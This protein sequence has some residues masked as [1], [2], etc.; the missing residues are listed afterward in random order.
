MTISLRIAAALPLVPDPDE[1]RRRAAEELAKPEYEAAQPTPLD[2]VAQAVGDF[3][4]GILSGEAPPGWDGLLGI[5]VV[6][7]A[8]LL[9]V[10]AVL[11]WGRPRAVRRSHAATGE[12]FARDEA[13]AA[14]LRRE[15]VARASARDWD[16]AIVL[17][18]RALARALAERTL[19]D[20]APGTTVHAF[21]RQAA[22]VFPA[23]GEALEASAKAFDDVRY[24]RRPG[25]AEL[26]ALVAETDDALETSRPAALPD[27]TA[28]FA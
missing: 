2:R 16:G 7:V 14:E 4:Q 3:L 22:R 18:M 21:A 5:V 26:Y 24:L 9:V 19:V 20:P 10:A 1:A 13:S 8:V 11:I 6:S 17:R 23:Q 27:P 15:A 25:T 28:A 12:L